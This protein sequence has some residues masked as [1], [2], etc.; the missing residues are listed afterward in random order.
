MYSLHQINLFRENQI[1]FQFRKLDKLSYVPF[2]VVQ[3]FTIL[4][5]A[6][7]ST[8]LAG[9]KYVENNFQT[10]QVLLYARSRVNFI[11]EKTFIR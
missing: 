11:S 6:V 4:L 8:A 2:E 1:F 3:L 9:I 10:C 5:L 7:V